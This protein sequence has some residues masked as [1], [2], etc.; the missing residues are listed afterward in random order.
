MRS[1]LARMGTAAVVAAIISGCGAPPGAYVS[2]QGY[3]LPA[4]HVSDIRTVLVQ[5]VHEAPP[6]GAIGAAVAG[7]PVVEADPG[8]GP[9]EARARA[10]RYVLHRDAASASAVAAGIARALDGTGDFLAAPAPGTVTI[11]GGLFSEA[12][13]ASVREARAEGISEGLLLARLV[14]CRLDYE[15]RMPEPPSERTGPYWHVSGEVKVRVRLANLRTGLT[16]LDRTVTATVAKEADARAR[17]PRAEELF[18]V[19]RRR[20]S[21]ACR[22]LL[23]SGREPKRMRLRGRPGVA[24]DLQAVNLA[25]AGQWPE[26]M[27]YWKAE[28]GKMPSALLE[29]NLGVACEALGLQDEARGHYR[30]AVLIEPG[31]RAF[32]MNLESSEN[33]IAILEK[34]AEVKGLRGE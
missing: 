27:S 31:Q 28:V 8:A 33:V 17:L 14:S 16:V 18:P 20:I 4:V 21:S 22:D 34:R 15:K 29:N 25:R 19:M 10:V 6:A 2:F 24:G 3:R 9:V 1:A 13:R 5:A 32:R 11:A 23:A 12:E 30:K 7:G 26:A